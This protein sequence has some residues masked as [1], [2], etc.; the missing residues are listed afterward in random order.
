MWLLIP[1]L[2]YT[3][4]FLSV[5]HV[6]SYWRRKGFPHEKCDLTWPF[7]KQV[8]KREFHHVD[9]I[10]EAY[11][12]G[13]ER[14]VGIYFLFHPTLLIRDLSLARAIMENPCGH[15]NDSKWDYF[16][17]YRK[18]NIMEKISP[19]FNA[20]RLE[21]IFRHIEKVGQ[22]TVNHFNAAINSPECNFSNG[23]DMQHA[24]RM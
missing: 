3:L 22:N 10:C 21:A 19:I 18:F 16:R 7:L 13:K 11:R 12:D 17:G 15:F 2:V 9:A 4:V 6:Y 1:I 14:F 20:S 24:L 5:R 23:I 8:Y